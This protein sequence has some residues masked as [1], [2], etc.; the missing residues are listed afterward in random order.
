M[1]R[2]PTEAAPPDHEPEALLATLAMSFEAAAEPTIDI[3]TQWAG[4]PTG[5]PFKMKALVKCTPP[6]GEKPNVAD[7]VMILDESLSMGTRADPNSAAA[8]LGK[9]C[10]DLFTHGVPGVELNLRVLLFGS[11]VVDKKIGSTDLVTLNEHSRDAFLAI[12]REITG[13]QGG[14]A[15]GEPI[16]KAIDILDSHRGQMKN[17]VETGTAMANELA[18]SQHIVVLTDGGANCGSYIDGRTLHDDIKEAVGNRNI[19]CHFIGVGPSINPGF[20]TA[21]T[22]KGKVGVF[23]SAPE[24]KDIANSY[25]EIFGFALETRT[26]LNLKIIDDEGERIERF[27]M[28][29]KERSILL[30]VTAPKNDST[31]SYTWLRVC[32]VNQDGEEGTPFTVANE[33]LDRVGPQGEA[34]LVKDAMEKEEVDRK[35]VEIQATSRNIEH[36]SQ[37]MREYTDT[38]TSEGAYGQA[39]LKRMN[40]MTDTVTEDVASYRS[41]GAQSSTICPARME[42]QSQ[43]Y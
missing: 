3:V 13:R 26:S 32:L 11:H 8:L 23:S 35:M 27:G 17:C 4:I 1:Q 16:L 6:V 18:P 37:R 34:V 20:I 28:L 33:W 15:I 21:V 10:E 19:F 7:V 25:E 41:L 38:M 30:D 24:G 39:A 22:D 42:T 14:T 36:A 31:G 5:A 43:Y 29:M 12:A 40:A 2:K 9:F